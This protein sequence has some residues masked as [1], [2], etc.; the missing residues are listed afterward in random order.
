L[1]SIGPSRKTGRTDFYV[2]QCSTK[3]VKMPEEKKIP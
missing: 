1:W 2:Q 3:L